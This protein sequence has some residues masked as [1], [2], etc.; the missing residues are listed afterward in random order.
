MGAAVILKVCVGD[1]QT[2][3]GRVV[4]LAGQVPTE[5][6]QANIRCVLIAD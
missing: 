3:F 6:P 4:A 5:L 2:N 1:I